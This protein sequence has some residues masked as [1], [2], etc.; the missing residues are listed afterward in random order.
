MREAAFW[1][2]RTAHAIVTAEDVEHAIDAEDLP[3]EPR[4]RAR[5]AADHRGH[6]RSSTPT[7]RRSARSTGSRSWPSAIT[8][9]AGRRASP[10]ARSP[11]SPGVARHR[12]RGEARRPAP[13]EG[14]DDPHRLP[15]RPLRARAP[16]RA[17]RPRSPSSSTTRRSTATAPPRRSSTRSSRASPDIPL[18]QSLAVTG[19]VNQRG[20]IQPVGGINEKI[21]GF[22]DVCRRRGLTRPAGRDHSRG[23]RA[24][25]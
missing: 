18:T 24:A 17:R 22:F 13:L 7:A 3:G 14:R 9:S 1:A 2:E 21:E 5:P 23:E 15:R 12:A 20:E 10:R 8:P 25:T 6:A 11:A 16:A 19:S 4:R